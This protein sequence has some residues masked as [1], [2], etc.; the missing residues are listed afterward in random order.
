MGNETRSTHA[1]TAGGLA[2]LTL[3]LAGPWFRAR[4]YDVT[5]EVASAFCTVFVGVVTYAVPA[6]LGARREPPSPEREP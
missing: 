1:A 4:G 2:T 3:W 5:P 6:Q